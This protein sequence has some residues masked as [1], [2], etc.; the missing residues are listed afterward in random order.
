MSLV[1]ICQDVALESGF[2]SP[3]TIVGNQDE[4]ARRLLALAKR[5]LRTLGS[6]DWSVLRKE[7][8]FPTVISQELYS[9]PSDF[10]RFIP[11]TNWDR[12]EFWA[13]Q[14]PLNA[15]EWQHFKSGII[16]DGPRLKFRIVPENGVNK[17]AL[18]PI[19]AEVKTLVFE[20]RSKNYAIASGGATKETFTLD[21]DE[22]LFPEDL[23]TL[24]LKWRFLSVLGLS[25]LEEREEYSRQLELALSRDGGSRILN[26]GDKHADRLNIQEAGFGS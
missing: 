18:F 3:A 13:L 17:F 25:Y 7:H 22:P 5:E 19:P 6:R 9:L 4:T 11:S 2:P 8:T 1:T 24:G 21:T 23:V 16:E 15:Q 26:M 10:D 12:G 20:Y 14:G